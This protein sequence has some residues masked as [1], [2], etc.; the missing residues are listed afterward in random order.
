M[1]VFV[2]GVAGF[3]GAVIARQLLEAGHTVTGCDS[4]IT[5]SASRVPADV[6]WHTT[7]LEQMRRIDADAVVHTAAIARSGWPTK[8]DLWQANVVATAHLADIVDRGV[9]WVH[10]SS[11]IVAYPWA[12]TY[13]RTKQVAE[14]VA[15]DAGAVVLRPGNIYGRGQTQSGPAPNVLAAMAR[16]AK[17]SG[18]VVVDGDGSQTRDFVHVSDVARAFVLAVEADRVPLRPL[19]VCTGAQTPIVELARRFGVPIVHGP[20]RGDPQEIVQD[21]WPI[22]QSLGWKPS[23]TLEQGL[24]EV[25]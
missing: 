19:D 11:S 16:S 1:K 24:A 13:A 14:D 2:T 7:P 15:W 25:L 18:R 5:G 8:A 20:S 6:H 12:S 22:M 4:M 10:C 17:L 3:L 9:R 23:V 21:R